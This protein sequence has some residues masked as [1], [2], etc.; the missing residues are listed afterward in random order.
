MISLL[1]AVNRT[2]DLYIIIFFIAFTSYVCFTLYILGV[3]LYNL[4]IHRNDNEVKPI[5][6]EFFI[7]VLSV[8]I[9]V[10]AFFFSG[11]FL[12]LPNW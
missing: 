1:I 11:Y 2:D 4:W 10:Y 3:L 8:A 6:N 12:F 9:L 5:R 7:L